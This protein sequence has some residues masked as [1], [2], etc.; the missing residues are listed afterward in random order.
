MVVGKPF[1]LHLVP[2]AKQPAAQ[3]KCHFLFP[4]NTV[5]NDAV[6][7]LLFNGRI[8]QIAECNYRG[9]FEMLVTH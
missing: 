9:V 6:L 5:A 4:T 8:I 2:G 7:L 3:L 1:G